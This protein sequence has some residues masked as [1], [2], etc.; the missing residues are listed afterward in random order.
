MSK[1]DSL[2]AIMNA[3]PVIPVVV[4]DDP[5]IAVQLAEALVKGGLPAI[6]ITLR[7]PNAI[8]CIRAVA[9]EVEGAVSGAGTVL[10]AKQMA[11][12]EKAGAKFMVSPGAAPEL[13]R[14]AADCPVPLLPGSATASEMMALGEAGYT[15]LKFFPAEAAG[16]AAFLKSVASPLP[17]FTICPTGGITLQSAAGY[18]ALP[19]V[20]CVGGSWVA[21]SG[22]M[23]KG[24]WAAIEALAREAVTLKTA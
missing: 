19:N 20:P 16:G 7:T 15:H 3:A 5:S 13:L 18:L 9:D 2:N 14:A 4:V 10:D 21:P 23:A 8:D 22:L 12:V 11:A 1:S 17:Q 6:E 24:D